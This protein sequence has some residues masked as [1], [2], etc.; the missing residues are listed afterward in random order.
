[1]LLDIRAVGGVGVGVGG[2]GGAQ[3]RPP[4]V[5]M[6]VSRARAASGGR[7][8]YSQASCHHYLYTTQQP[9]HHSTEP[10]EQADNFTPHQPP[11]LHSQCCPHTCVYW[12]ENT[13]LVCP[14]VWRPACELQMSGLEPCFSLIG[15][16]S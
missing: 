1:M 4:S 12:L 3:L 16:Y 9:P 8:S 13:A 2:G 6:P 5:H 7:A 14:R 11:L 15:V 10:L